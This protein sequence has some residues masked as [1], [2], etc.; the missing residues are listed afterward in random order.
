MTIDDEAGHCAG[1]VLSKL[2]KVDLA[3]LVM[4]VDRVREDVL[5]ED[6]ML[7]LLMAITET[8]NMENNEE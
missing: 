3:G 5:S 1:L 2:T 6:P 4:S 7:H 8:K